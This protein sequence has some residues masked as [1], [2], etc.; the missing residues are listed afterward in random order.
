MSKQNFEIEVTDEYKQILKSIRDNQITFCSGSAGTGKSTFIRYLKTILPKALCCA[1]TGVAALNIGGKTIHYTF[2]L[3]AKYIMPADIKYMPA[4]YVSFIK[5]SGLI[6]ID[7]ISMVSS[8]VLD[9]VDISLRKSMKTNVPFGGMKILLIGDL[10]QLPPVVTNSTLEITNSQ[11]DSQYFFDANCIKSAINN[12]KFGMIQLTKVKRQNDEFFIDI[13]QNVRT[14]KNIEDT[15]DILNSSCEINPHYDGSKNI[16]HITPYRAT[17]ALI[18]D[19]QLQSIDSPS[20]S[21]FGLIDGIINESNFPVEQ[22]ITLKVG[23]KV[24]TLENDKFGRYVN[25]TICTVTK[26]NK[27]S[28]NVDIDG[29]DVEINLRSWPEYR[30]KKVDGAYK[31][32]LVG[33]FRQLPIKLSWSVTIHKVQGNTLS[34]V[35]IDLDKGSFAHGMTYVALSRCKTLEG[36]I[37]SRK[38]TKE[39]IILDNRIIEFYSKFVQ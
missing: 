19:T 8:N 38:V 34:N 21:Y 27:E 23:A 2:K 39:D 22:V 17:S 15:I 13:L 3:P 7:E 25:G 14:N 6:I 16:L 37:L 35:Y 28:I 32:S 26:L 30:Y 9:S 12:K 33:V 10:F 1:P 5:S 29:L 20:K 24:M 36:I 31:S 11:Y 4:D 18:N